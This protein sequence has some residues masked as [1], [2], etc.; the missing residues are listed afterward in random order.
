M[1]PS[2]QSESSRT[3]RKKITRKTTT[4]TRNP[5]G[6]KAMISRDDR[7]LRTA[8]PL[9]FWS[10]MVTGAEYGALGKTKRVVRPPKGETYQL[11]IWHCPTK[12]MKVAKGPC[13][14]DTVRPYMESSAFAERSWHNYK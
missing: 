10:A 5:F 7:C 8:Y 9:T 11:K 12:N 14:S 13:E 1:Q 2:P 3:A 4:W 6:G